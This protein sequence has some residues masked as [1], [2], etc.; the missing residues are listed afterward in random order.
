MF[1]P[2]PGSDF[3]HPG[4]RIRTV[5]I[6]DTGT[7]SKNLSILTPKKAKKWFPSSKKYPDPDTDFLPSRIPGSKRHPIPNP[8]SATQMDESTAYFSKEFSSFA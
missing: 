8:G 4:P 2:G 1:I 7:S 5:S 3:F 6:P